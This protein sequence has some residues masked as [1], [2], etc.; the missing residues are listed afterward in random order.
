M[1]CL[2]LLEKRLRNY[3][4]YS[5]WHQRILQGS[6]FNSKVFVILIDSFFH[7]PINHVF[8]K[9]NSSNE[10][11]LYG[12]LQGTVVRTTGCFRQVYFQI[13]LHHMNYRKR[14]VDL[15][16]LTDPTAISYFLLKKYWEYLKSKMGT[17]FNC[18]WYFGEDFLF[19]LW[20]SFVGCLKFGTIL[21]SRK[22]MNAEMF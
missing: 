14:F 11:S 18:H 4:W 20:S 16:L 10:G 9:W 17:E 19:Q 5:I 6:N 15:K 1:S 21:I 3:S 22:L 8:L 12:K 7:I 2:I 13:T